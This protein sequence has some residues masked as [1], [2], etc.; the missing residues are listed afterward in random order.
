MAGRPQAG[1]TTRLDRLKEAKARASKLKQGAKLTA[2]PMADLLR[3]RW[4]TLRDWCDEI[5]ALESRGAVIRGGNG[6]EWEFSARKVI[7]I[8]IA[9]FQSVID[10]QAKK[11]QQIS[12]AI[13]VD[14]PETEVPTLAETKD[15]VNLTLTVVAASEKQGRYT[16]T[17]EMTAFIAEYNQRVVDGIMGVRTQ[18]DPNGN[19]PPNVRS[20]V[21]K[22]LRSV[23]TQV[24]A[25]AAAFIEECRAD[26]RQAG[27]G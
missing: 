10:G 1:L 3:V 18:V 17:E 26:I 7:N 22:Y 16:L 6:I 15:L 23:A 14:L 27:T 12:R 24:H 19:L 13:G 21:D 9:H 8:L 5:P 4:A 20:D 25:K 2:Q 11:S